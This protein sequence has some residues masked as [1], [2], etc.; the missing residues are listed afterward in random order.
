[1]KQVDELSRKGNHAVGIIEGSQC[2]LLSMEN[3]SVT[4]SAE[5]FHLFLDPWL[6]AH[7]GVEVDYIHGSEVLFDLSS[8]E[9]NIGFYLPSIDKASFFSLISKKGPMPRKTFSIGEAE[10]KR[11]YL[12][13]RKIIL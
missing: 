4:L 6:D 8:E 1:M 11:Y 2:L 3:P 9:K 7:K 12:E 10:E 13:S 5:A